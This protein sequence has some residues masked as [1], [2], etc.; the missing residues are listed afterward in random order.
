MVLVRRC[1]FGPRPPCGDRRL[2]GALDDDGLF[3]LLVQR[4]DIHPG[5]L[6]LFSGVGLDRPARLLLF[7]NRWS[8]ALFGRLIR[9]VHLLGR[10]GPYR[11]L[12][13]LGLVRAGLELGRFTR[14]ALDEFRLLH[15]AHV[16]EG[17]SLLALFRDAI[18]VVL[19]LRHLRN[20]RRQPEIAG[21]DIDGF[22]RRR[23]G[24]FVE[25]GVTREVRCGARLRDSRFLCRRRGGRFLAFGAY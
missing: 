15:R 14:R 17:G 20:F 16:R 18:R 24:D 6:R 4:F 19:G 23:T 7:V 25:P 5:R 1:R 12:P 8:D 11:R 10:L 2:L 13:G 9:D 21:S 3:A 22:D